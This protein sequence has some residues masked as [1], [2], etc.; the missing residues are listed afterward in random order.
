M[1][2][3]M[4]TGCGLQTRSPSFLM[5]LQ[6]LGP[7]LPTTLTDRGDMTQLSRNHPKSTI[8]PLSSLSVHTEMLHAAA[9]RGEGGPGCLRAN[10]GDLADVLQSALSNYVDGR[11][12]HVDHAA[13]SRAPDIPQIGGAALQYRFRAACWRTLSPG[14][15]PPCPPH[16]LPFARPF[17]R[18]SSPPP[19][20]DHNTIAAAP[21]AGVRWHNSAVN[22]SGEAGGT[23]MRGRRC[24]QAGRDGSSLLVS[25]RTEGFVPF[26]DRNAARVLWRAAEHLGDHKLLQRVEF[27]VLALPQDLVR[28]QEAN[29][30]G[31]GRAVDD[32]VAQC[33]VV[34]FHVV[35]CLLE[36]PA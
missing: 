29:L 27:S 16:A 4:Q 11:H 2:L 10:V 32:A 22:D 20:P 5:V 33:A 13:A 28:C 24:G 25:H 21:Y 26:A 30:S 9:A 3:F 18:T 19:G 7:P 12:A 6:K 34:V 35:A 1:V 36:P 17:C 15:R 8:S 14:P 31:N 23:R